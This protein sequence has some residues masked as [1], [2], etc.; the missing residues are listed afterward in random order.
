MESLFW[1]LVRSF[2]R[3]R[4]TRVDDSG[5]VQLAQMQLSANETHDAMPC[6]AL[7]GFQ[8]CPPEGSDALAVFLGGDRTNGVIIATGNQRY[9]FRNLVPGEACISD[10]RGQSVYL[11]ATGIIVNG[12]GNLVTITNAPEI[13][14]DTPL[15]HCTGDIVGDGNI[16]C[17][18]DM[19]DN[20]GTNAHTAADTRAVYTSHRHPVP[21]V[22]GGSDTVTS[23]PP[24]EPL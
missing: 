16:T 7:Y 2:G 9:R 15:L 21:S 4:L 3:G 5:P 13:T 12:G 20:S 1:S 11:T 8:S 23:D 6:L 19:L 10:N 18:G 17:A 24:D 14:A 22:Q